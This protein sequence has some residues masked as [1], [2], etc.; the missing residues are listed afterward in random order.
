MKYKQGDH[1][2]VVY[3]NHPRTNKAGLITLA[4]E[5]EETYEIK[6]DHDS[7]TDRWDMEDKYF[8]YSY[9]H[10]SPLAQALQ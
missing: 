8:E 9:V 4:N 10:N 3:K 1:V 6:F 2:V 7:T 5:K